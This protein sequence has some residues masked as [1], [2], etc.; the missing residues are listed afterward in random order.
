MPSEQVLAREYL[1]NGRMLLD[2]HLYPFLLRHVLHVLAERIPLGCM[3]C[4]SMSEAVSVPGDETRLCRFII[5]DDVTACECSVHRINEGRDA[6]NIVDLLMVV[7][8]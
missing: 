7:G 4:L 6:I 3:K 5:I 1:V 8:L 2:E